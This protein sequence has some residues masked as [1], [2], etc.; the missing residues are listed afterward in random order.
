MLDVADAALI[1]GDNALR[2]EPADAGW[3]WLD[4][5]E[6]WFRLTRLPMVFAT[7]A[8][9]PELG[10]DRYESLVRES[11]AFGKNAIEAIVEAESAS[12]GIPKQ[13]AEEHLKRQLHYELGPAEHRGLE[14]FLKMAELG[15][16]AYG[17]V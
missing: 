11:Y 15:Q 10:L 8:G 7:W 3:D 2:I 13:L 6:E 14:T 17:S 1:I 9:R 4:L 16:V 5:G 12:R